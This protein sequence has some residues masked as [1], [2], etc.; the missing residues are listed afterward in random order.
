MSTSAVVSFML[1]DLLLVFTPGA[2][3][4]YIV[5]SGARG[6][7][8]VAAVAG[9]VSGYGLHTLLVAAGVAAV[10]AASPA[11]LTAM[12]VAGA[13]YLVCI[14]A[15]ALARPGPAAEAAE[16]VSPSPLRV[17]LGGVAT[18]GLNPKGLLV[19][20]ALI[21][22]FVIA[23]GTVPVGVQA[24]LLGA[25]HMA[26]CAAGY[27]L[28]GAVVRTT[29]SNRPLAARRVTQVAGGAMV[30]IGGLLLVQRWLGL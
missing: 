27:L 15:V 21:P 25:L 26:N 4:A 16:L 23:D 22:Q 3:W 10:V 14:G 5:A 20:L 11:A 30:T 29:L 8:V 9:L 19:F 7:P 6:R 1:V 12:T 2:D 17:A 18:S 13:G 24:G 28:I